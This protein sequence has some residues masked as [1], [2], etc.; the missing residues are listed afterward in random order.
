MVGRLNRLQLKPEHAFVYINHGQIL[1]SN[2]IPNDVRST[3]T[4]LQGETFVFDRSTD[5]QVYNSD[6]VWESLHVTASTFT[7]SVENRD[8]I[9]SFC[10]SR[11]DHT[12]HKRTLLE[13]QTPANKP[14]MCIYL[15]RNL[16]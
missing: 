11:F 2:P 13:T 1:A 12:A 8:S 9:E 5:F 16:S 15:L 10:T 7:E 14:C 3:S 4:I 6:R